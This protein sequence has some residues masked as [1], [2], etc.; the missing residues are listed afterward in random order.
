MLYKL[1]PRNGA[2]TTIRFATVCAFKTRPRI[3]M[4]DFMLRKVLGCFEAHVTLITCARPIIAMR[5]FVS[6]PLE[7]SLKAF[8]TYITHVTRTILALGCPV[9]ILEPHGQNHYCHL[10]R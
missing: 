10:R 1:V 4:D 7:R 8:S 5:S 9:H 6:F 3:G 2:P